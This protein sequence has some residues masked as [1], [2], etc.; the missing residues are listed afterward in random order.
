MARQRGRAVCLFQATTVS[1]C[2]VIPIDSIA[3]DEEEANRN[4]R[5]LTFRAEE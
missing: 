5:A 2:L 3:E 4:A 1:R